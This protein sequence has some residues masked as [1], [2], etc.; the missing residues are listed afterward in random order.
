ATFRGNANPFCVVVRQFSLLVVRFAFR[1]SE[2]PDWS[3]A[4][5]LTARAPRNLCAMV[6]GF[7]GR[8][9]LSP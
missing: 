7:V 1:E 2:W 5:G 6:E 4:N 9:I 8:A 3:S